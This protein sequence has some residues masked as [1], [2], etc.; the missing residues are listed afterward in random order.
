MVAT[1]VLSVVV[2]LFGLWAGNQMFG[3]I[4]ISAMIGGAVGVL[5]GVGICLVER[6]IGQLE[7]TINQLRSDNSSGQTGNEPKI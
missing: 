3:D 4:G 2:G 5:T 6:K 7:K 1:G